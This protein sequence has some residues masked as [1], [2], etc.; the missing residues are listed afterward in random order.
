MQWRPVGNAAACCCVWIILHVPAPPL[1]IVYVADMPV[2]AFWVYF[3][4]HSYVRAHL[5]ASPCVSFVVRKDAGV[6][7]VSFSRLLCEGGGLCGYLWEVVV[8]GH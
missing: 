5:L 1:Q 7:I 8:Q 6:W 4:A 2:K 3:F